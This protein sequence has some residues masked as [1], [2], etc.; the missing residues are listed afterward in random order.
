M[1]RGSCEGGGE[2]DAESEHN[3]GGV[4]GDPRECIRSHALQIRSSMRPACS[5]VGGRGAVRAPYTVQHAG[6]AS[7]VYPCGPEN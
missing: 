1:L 2:G 3:T 7:T 6:C 4:A 5:A